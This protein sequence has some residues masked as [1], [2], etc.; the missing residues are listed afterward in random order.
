MSTFEERQNAA[1]KLRSHI[2]LLNSA[3]LQAREV[4]LD[5]GIGAYNKDDGENNNFSRTP[6]I[7]GTGFKHLLHLDFISYREKM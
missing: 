5:L 1:A 6:V 2:A 4:G 3:V 7:T